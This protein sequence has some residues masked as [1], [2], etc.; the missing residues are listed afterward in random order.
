MKIL[1]IDTATE[2]C[3][4]ALLIGQEII[5]KY[6]LKSTM[7]STG[8]SAAHSRSVLQMVDELLQ[9]SS[10]SLG[11]L[12][13]IAVNTGPGSF[14]GV[15][16]SLGVAQG[17]AY[18][19]DLPVIG[20]CSLAVLAASIDSGVV[21]PAIDARMNQVYCGIYEV[22]ESSKPI[23]RH[24]PVVVDPGSIP[25]TVNKSAC[26]L[27]SGWDVYGDAI[28]A[29]IGHSE[30]NRLSARYPQAKYVAKVAQQSGLESAVAP[31][32]LQATYVRNDIVGSP[33]RSAI[34]GRGVTGKR[35]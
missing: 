11:N 22:T 28:I 27:G 10:F 34:V 31:M 35:A 32:Q 25:F 16:I 4:V 30:I 15:R 7:P 17:L 19:A 5:Q 14:T 9:K 33:K 20:V 13:A 12:D 24:R 3:S 29:G 1:A 8:Q 2:A 6:A 18:G 26:G 23:Q 21:L